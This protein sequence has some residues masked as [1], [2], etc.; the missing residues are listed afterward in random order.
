MEKILKESGNVEKTDMTAL[1]TDMLADDK[2]SIDIARVLLTEIMIKDDD[3]TDLTDK[4]IVH[5]AILEGILRVMPSP[6]LSQLIKSFKR[7]RKSHKRKDR[8]EAVKMV[9]SLREESEGIQS[10]LKNLLG[11]GT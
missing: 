5:L 1:L 6:F 2:K 10:K 3:Y 7:L 9:Q 4:Q 8:Q 11:V